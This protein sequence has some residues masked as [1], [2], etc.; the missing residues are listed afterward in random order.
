MP[1][2]K[3]WKNYKPASKSPAPIPPR[4]LRELVGRLKNYHRTPQLCG[5]W[6][7]CAV[8]K[9]GNYYNLTVCNTG[10]GLVDQFTLEGCFTRKTVNKSQRP[11][12]IIA[13]S[14]S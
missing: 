9:C 6:G 11:A 13:T 2:T 5:P 1:L 3:I 10:N 8:Q 4:A 7:L 12:G 14:V